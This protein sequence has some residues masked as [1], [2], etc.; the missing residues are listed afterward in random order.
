M[1]VV[2]LDEEAAALAAERDEAR[3]N[4]DYARADAIRRELVARGW[5]VED[6]PRGTIVRR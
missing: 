3:H 6:T 2:E 4:K 5:V 1:P